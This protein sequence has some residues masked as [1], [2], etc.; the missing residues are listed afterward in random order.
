MGKKVYD[1]E[2]IKL[3]SEAGKICAGILAELRDFSKEGVTML[4]VDRLAESLCHKH[5][6]QPAFKGYHGFPA[7]VCVGVDD[8]V[9]HGI[10][11]DYVLDFGDVFSIDFGIKYKGVFSDT[12][13]TLIIGDAP[14]ETKKFV[15]TVKETTMAGIRAAIPGNTVGDIGHAMQSVAEK[16]G[17]SIVREMVG[18]GIGHELHEEPNVP[19]YGVPGRGMRLYRGQTLAIEAI[20]NQGGP[21][22]YISSDDGWT[23]YTNDGMLSALFEHTVVVDET[24]QILTA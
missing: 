23:S 17:Y 8:V 6:V 13:T 2:K 11:D 19:G 20:V 16:A 7:C 3:M 1:E 14:D 21:E 22:I 24:P 18:H 15:N 5:G 9:V 12:S 4:D 10:P